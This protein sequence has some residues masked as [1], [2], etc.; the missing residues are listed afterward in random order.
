MIKKAD[1]KLGF[2][3]SFMKQ[4]RTIAYLRVSTTDQDVDKNKNDILHLANEKVSVQVLWAVNR[5][6]LP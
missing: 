3:A 6:N 4:P 5:L 1:K 2:C